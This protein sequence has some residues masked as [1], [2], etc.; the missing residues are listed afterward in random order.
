METISLTYNGGL[1]SM[2]LYEFIILMTLCIRGKKHLRWGTMKYNIK[3][4]S[5]YILK[6][7]I[8]QHSSQVSLDTMLYFYHLINMI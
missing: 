7:Q 8:H 3:Y 6:L 4:T 2:T 5:E 1:T